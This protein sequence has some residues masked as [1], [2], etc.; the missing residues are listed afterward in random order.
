MRNF[1]SKLTD[2]GPVKPYYYVKFRWFSGVDLPTVVKNL[3]HSFSV[4][5]VNLPKNGFYAV[6]EF[7]FSEREHVR[8]QADTLTAR[9]SPFRVILYQR[10][11]EPFTE[12]DMALRKRVL[13]LYPRHRPTVGYQKEPPFL[14]KYQEIEESD[15]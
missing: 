6:S 12:R 9:L 13:D 8:V 7:P 15:R 5:E 3:K 2:S 10:Q 1:L 14:V 11:L 4:E